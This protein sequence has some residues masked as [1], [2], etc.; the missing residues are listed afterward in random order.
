LSSRAVVQSFSR[1]GRIVV[2][3]EQAGRAGRLLPQ[4]LVVFWCVR[5]A[6]CA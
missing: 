1:T 4:I 2:K 5:F 3:V 6:V